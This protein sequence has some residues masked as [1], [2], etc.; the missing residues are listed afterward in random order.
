ML[1]I[2]L[3]ALCA[4]SLLLTSCGGGAPVPPSKEDILRDKLTDKYHMDC[5][6]DLTPEVSGIMMRR[7]VNQEVICYVDMGHAPSCMRREIEL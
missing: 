4:G 6:H 5:S 7:C 1:R 3:I 2:R